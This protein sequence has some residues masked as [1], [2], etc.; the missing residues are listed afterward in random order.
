MFQLFIDGPWLD[1]TLCNTIQFQG[2]VWIRPNL[3]CCRWV[4]QPYYP[5][6]CS[7]KKVPETGIVNIALRFKA[8]ALLRRK[9]VNQQQSHGQDRSAPVQLGAAGHDIMPS[10]KIPRQRYVCMCET[11]QSKGAQSKPA[12]VN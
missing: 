12:A 7:W 4:H 1:N 9:G 11:Y 2:L 8:L 3:L 6:V 5:H 10:N